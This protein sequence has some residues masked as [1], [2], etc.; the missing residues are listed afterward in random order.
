MTNPT[1]QPE[2]AGAGGSLSDVAVSFRRG[3]EAPR[4]EEAEQRT[5]MGAE[6]LSDLIARRRSCRSYAAA[7]VPRELIDSCL[8]A[9]RLAPSA[10]NSQPWTFVVVDRDPIRSQLARAAF[11]GAHSQNA[12]CLEAPVLLAVITERERYAARMGS[13]LRGEQYAMI[14]IG[15]AGE[16]LNLRAAELGLGCCWLGRFDQQAVKEVLGL[17]QETRIDI[18]FS[19]GYPKE[20]RPREKRRRPLDQIRRYA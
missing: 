6:P 20:D 14:D 8:E 9:A 18:M 7:P 16:H 3:G 13:H 2:P 15:I 12:F 5:A 1:P 19:L 10:C 11:S 17:P 4:P